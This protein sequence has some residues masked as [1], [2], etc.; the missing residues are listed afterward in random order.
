MSTGAGVEEGT[1]K[2]EGF[3]AT[4]GSG[5]FGL[6]AAKPPEKAG[7]VAV[8]C[9][10]GVKDQGKE[11]HVVVVVPSCMMLKLLADSLRDGVGFPLSNGDGMSGIL[12][13]GPLV[14][15]AHGNITTKAGAATQCN[16]KMQI[17]LSVAV[18]SNGKSASPVL[19]RHCSLTSKVV[20]GVNE[21]LV[22]PMPAAARKLV[23]RLLVVAM[24]I[25]GSAAFASG[26]CANGGSKG[27]HRQAQHGFSP[28]AKFA[29]VEWQVRHD[30][31]HREERE[32]GIPNS[33]AVS[34]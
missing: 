8:N 15:V 23:A 3:Q 12:G 10:M 1:K 14:W 20:K 28:G 34:I 18:G 29:A 6:P 24:G 11:V 25:E 7:N 31:Q 27:G 2:F 21:K 9:P 13:R 32:G 5:A 19:A 22:G 30:G 26:A 16:R 33:F 17:T 4:V